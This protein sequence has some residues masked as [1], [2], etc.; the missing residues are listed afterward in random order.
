MSSETG[1]ALL[2]LSNDLAGAVERAA[3][4]VVAV[5]A[6]QRVPSSGVHWR[7]GVIVTAAHTIKRDEEITVTLPDGGSAPAVLAGFDP[8]T[9]LA[10][11]KASGIALPVA[12]TA[13]VATLRVGHL[14]LAVAR[15]GDEGPSASLGVI[16]ALGGPW[17]TWRGGHVDQ[18]VR[19]DLALYPGFSGG[20]LI[21]TEGRVLGINT[22]GLS[23]IGGLVI[24]AATINRVAS[25]LLEKGR[26]T[27]GYLGV[28]MQPVRLPD[29]LRNKL[30]LT[31]GTGVIVLSVEPDGPAG[32][33][34]MLVGDIITALGDQ[35]VADTDDVQ[36]AL[37]P[38]SVGRELKASVVRGGEAAELV[39]T[40][41]ER[42]GRS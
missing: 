36:A 19:P 3:R 11:L 4:S 42:P 26:V 32:R 22:S 38:E 18:Y 17:R 34:G 20:P 15:P 39:I 9:D 33:A 6:R 40:V 10:V 13:D 24:P 30:G 2:A 21:D 29:A 41:G 1:G 16:S 5:H 12:E 14:V 31:H 7:E 28:S 8:G 27:R 23:R 37:G 25:V 35:P